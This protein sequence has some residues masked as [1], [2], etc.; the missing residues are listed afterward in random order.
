M[1]DRASVG[2]LFRFSGRGF[3]GGA[4][5]LAIPLTAAH[6]AALLVSLDAGSLVGVAGRETSLEH[7]GGFDEVV[8]DGDD[9]V[10]GRARCICPRWMSSPFSPA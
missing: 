10:A 6:G 3:C 8:V 2:D 1:V 5:L 9:P 4:I 7:V